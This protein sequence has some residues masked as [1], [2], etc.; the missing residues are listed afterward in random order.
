MGV[1][2]AENERQF[3]ES[4]CAGGCAGLEKEIHMNECLCVYENEKRGVW[5]DEET[6]TDA[7]SDHHILCPVRSPDGGGAYGGIGRNQYM[8]IICHLSGALP[9]HRI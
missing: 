8:D 3:H 5:Y 9:G 4:L 6:E 1:C 2:P 7:G